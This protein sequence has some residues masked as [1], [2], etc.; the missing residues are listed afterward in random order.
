MVTAFSS[1]HNGPRAADALFLLGRSLG[2]LGQ[3]SEACVTLA[4]VDKRFPGSAAAGEA[5]AAR[6]EL[7][8]N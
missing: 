3:T 8:C 6:T 5:Q 7:G 1:A 4:E 2:K